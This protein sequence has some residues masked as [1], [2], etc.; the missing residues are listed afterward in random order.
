M[1]DVQ[2]YEIRGK[3]PKLQWLQDPDEIRGDNLKM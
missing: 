2:N 3:K 1:K